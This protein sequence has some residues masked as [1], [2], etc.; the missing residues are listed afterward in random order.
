MLANFCSSARQVERSPTAGHFA[1]T[2]STPTPQGAT[3]RATTARFRRLAKMAVAKI[4][5][6]LSQL[7]QASKTPAPCHASRTSCSHARQAT[8]HRAHTS[9]LRQQIHTG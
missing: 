2:R 5:T 9:A 8:V 7:C 6:F 1:K 3:P 4:Y